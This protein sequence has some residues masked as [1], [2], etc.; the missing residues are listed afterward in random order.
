MTSVRLGM[1]TPSSN[2]VLEPVTC[3]MLAGLDDVTAHFTRVQVKTVGLERS[4]TAQFDLSRMLAAAK[5]LA[6]V[7]P[8]VIAWNGTSASWLGLESDAELCRRIGEATGIPTIS[9]TLVLVGLLAAAGYT[10]IGLVTPYTDDVQ[11]RIVEN[12]AGAGLGVMAERHLSLSDSFSYGQIGQAMIE[13]MIR[14][15]A[16]ERPEVVVP[17]CTNLGA[18]A[19]VGRLEAELDV[20]IYDSVAVTLCG[21][22]GA[23]GVDPARVQGW[24][25]LF[26]ARTRVL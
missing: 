20:P 11:E 12:L 4:A 5:P 6:D 2:T 18:A 3:A 25:R 9:T 8:A 15:V 17:L 26:S 7:E 23:A 16:T 19:L 24:G 22:L 13:R 14:E 10:R 1:L 21:A